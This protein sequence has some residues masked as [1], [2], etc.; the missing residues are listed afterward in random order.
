MFIYNQLILKKYLFLI[1]IIILLFLLKELNDQEI[2]RS[3]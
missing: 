2:C 1:N 3:H